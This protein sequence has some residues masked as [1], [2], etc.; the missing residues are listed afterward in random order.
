MLNGSETT[1]ISL[2]VIFALGFVYWGFRRAQPYGKLGILAW[3]QSVLL[4][5]PWL[6]FF[7]FLGLGIYLNI[8]AILFLLVV[9]VIIYIWLGNLIRAEGQSMMWQKQVK[10]RLPKENS[11][12][13]SPQEETPKER[14]VPEPIPID[15]EDLKIIKGIFGIDTF[16]ATES[17]SYQEGAIFRGNLRGEADSVHRR[18]SEKLNK[19]FGDKYHLFLV[20][21]PEEK[22]VVIVLPSRNDP[23]PA[24]LAQKNLA[25]VLLVATIATSLEAASLLQGF[26]W[27]GELG[28]FSEVLPIA[29]G[30]GLILAA[31]EMGHRAI[32][33]QYNITMGLPFFIPSWQIGSFGAIT[34]FESILPHR[35]ALFDIAFAGPAVGGIMSL[36]ILILGLILSHPGSIFEIPSEFF[37][38]SI[39]IGI[40][41][42]II[43]GSQLQQPL[44]EVNLLTVIG[45]LGLNITALN[46]MPAGQL[47]GGRIVQG[48]YG[49]KTAR[50][51]TIATLIL[52]GLVVIFNPGNSIVLYWAIIILFLQRELERPSLNELTE[53]DDTRAGLAFLALLLMLVVLLPLSPNFAVRLGIGIV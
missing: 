23:Q 40:L 21:S 16:F 9:C 38:S 39:L 1:A 42:K 24:T 37:Q 32:A 5:T 49:R 45:W 53:P 13:P 46:L 20:E 52:L 36:L 35:T 18:L 7:I 26:D 51:T 25:L 3:L 44:V 31:H 41:G 33:Q 50:K 4:M 11:S 14:I 17:I 19:S 29:L 12:S 30:L 10:E 43:L 2:L 8:V 6:I 48:I 27:F 34:R 28:R 47:D 15:P 22:P